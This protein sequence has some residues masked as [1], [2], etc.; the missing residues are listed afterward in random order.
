MTQPRTVGLF[1]MDG[2][3]DGRIKCSLDNWV[4]KVYLI[5][6][7]EVARSK[8]R[9]E[10]TQTGIY[11]LLGTRA[12]SGNDFVYVG[13]AQ[14]RKNGNGVLGRVAEHLYEKEKDYFTHAIV[15][16]DSE[17]SFGPTEIS[18]LE[19]AF[20]ELAKDADRYEVTN[21]NV[22]PSGNVTEEKQASLDKF[23]AS[24]K[25]IIS[26][27]GYRVFDPVIGAGSDSSSSAK[28]RSSPDER[29]LYLSTST[30]SGEG[31]QTSDGFVVLKGAHLR[32]EV[33]PTV[34]KL[35]KMNRKKYSNRISADWILLQDT[36]FT[37]PSA[38]SDFITGS[39]TSGKRRWTN[40][41]G[42]PL[43]ELEK[44]EATLPSSRKK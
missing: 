23:I 42:T 4:G 37:S 43:G 21:R 3:S 16:I 35:A 28:Y 14:E 31:R 6:R 26:A 9:P 15:I 34:P 22:P 1:L 27:L 30:S 41:E 18:Y 10:L 33:T 32:K 38:A 44:E 5:P 20:Y 29:T 7:T 2:T 12:A 39:S 8:D 13:Q 40:K 11:L 36:L 25:T 24:S 17:N 19:N